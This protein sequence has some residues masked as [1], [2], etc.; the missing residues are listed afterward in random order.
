MNKT[1][2]VALDLDGTLVEYGDGVQVNHKLIDQV[3]GNGDIKTAVIVT[4]QGGIPLGYRTAFQ[5]MYRLNAVAEAIVRAGGTVLFVTVCV[6][7]KKASKD[8]V[9]VARA[10]TLSLCSD[11]TP[12]THALTETN[13]RVFTD[14]IYRKPSGEMTQYLGIKYSVTAFYG[15][16]DDDEGEAAAAGVPFIRVDRFTGG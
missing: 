11:C 10:D 1:D 8:R 12:W 4:N 16:S 2:C 13:I 5:F 7:H 15:D 3:I 9:L 6:W 14:A